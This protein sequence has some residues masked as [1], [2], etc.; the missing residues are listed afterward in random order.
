[1]QLT[2]PPPVATLNCEELISSRGCDKFVEV[3]SIF[4]RPAG[5]KEPTPDWTGSTR[6][7]DD[8]DEDDVHCKGEGT[9]GFHGC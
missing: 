5:T 2:L 3:R 6:T 9:A 1:M 7:D 4:L 8:E